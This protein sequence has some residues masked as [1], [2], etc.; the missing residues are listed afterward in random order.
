MLKS[1]KKILGAKLGA[2]DG[3]IGH[4]KDFYFDDQ[5]WAVR[6]VMA[7]TGTWIPARQVLISPHA[8]KSLD[9]A[10]KVLEVNLTRKQIE[11]S[12]PVELH[13]PVSRQYEE[14][15]YRY[16]KWPFYWQGGA[17]WGIS[18][19]PMV[20]PLTPPLPKNPRRHPRRDAHLRSALGVMGYHIQGT[21]QEFGKI[22][23]FLMDDETWA[24]DHVII[25]TGHW[26]AGRKVLLAP[27][28]VEHIS[29][30]DSKVFIDSSKAAIEH[31]PAYEEK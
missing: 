28:E 24:I 6:Y 16:Y 23:D 27:L 31:A 10:D 2:T 1:L 5:D 19:F 25:D 21:D 12:P 26:L 13:K 18:D 9:A 17:L 3:H 4:V 29:W 7:D 20:P 30:S 8:L 14:E 15:Y 11:N 22:A